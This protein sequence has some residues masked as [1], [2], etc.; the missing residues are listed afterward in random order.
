LCRIA[1]GSHSR[2]LSSVSRRWGFTSLPRHRSRRTRWTGL[3]RVAAEKRK[4][5]KDAEKA[6][7]RKRMRARDAL[8]R[9]RRRQERDGLPRE[10]SPETP[11][12]DDDDEDDDE[13]DD[14]AARL[15]LSLDLRLGQGS[16]SQQPRGLAP[17]V[18]GVGASGSQFEERGQAEGVLDP[19]AE[20]VEVTPGSQAESPV[21]EEPLPVPAVQEGDP[22]VAVAVLGQSVPLVPRAPEARMKP[23]AGLTSVV[24]SEI[25]AQET[26]PQA[27]L[28]VARSG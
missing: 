4:E 9:L 23:A 25:E 12:D 16:S 15:G 17:L 6:R 20:V 26:S 8:E 11:D 22:R 24:P 21:S 10:P 2:D 19:L 3:R 5:K 13:D 27:R 18:S 7:A 14:M 1:L 28:I